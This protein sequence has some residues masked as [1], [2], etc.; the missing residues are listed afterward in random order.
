MNI[1]YSRTHQGLSNSITDDM[2]ANGLHIARLVGCTTYYYQLDALGSGRY[3]T[4]STAKLQ[5]SSNYQPF[6]LNYGMT[7]TE[8]FMYTGKPYD[9]DSNDGLYFY[10]ARIYD[11]YLGRFI[12]EDTVTGSLTDPLSQNRYIYAEDNPESYVDPTGHF[13]NTNLRYDEVDYSTSF[14]SPGTT[15]STE[16]MYTDTVL[17]IPMTY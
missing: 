15:A 5:F 12:T 16:M 2:Y 10:G 1:I 13:V 3:V 11:D 4:T 8:T 6:G 9:H 7:G 14:S 17:N